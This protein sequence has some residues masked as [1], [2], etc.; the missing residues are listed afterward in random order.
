VRPLKRGNAPGK[1]FEGWPRLFSCRLWMLLFR[2]VLSQLA[3]FQTQILLE[4]TVGLLRPRPLTKWFS[5]DTL[6]HGAM[7]SCWLSDGATAKTI[8]KGCR[9]FRGQGIVQMLPHLHQSSKQFAYHAGERTRPA[10]GFLAGRVLRPR[11]SLGR[12]QPFS[13]ARRYG[14]WPVT[15]LQNLQKPGCLGFEG[16]ASAPVRRFG[17]DLVLYTLVLKDA[18][19]KLHSS[20]TAPVE[21]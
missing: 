8:V 12:W 1:P 13:R 9:V 21:R 16:P 7:P 6:A 5:H 2:S 3:A 10:E 19:M 4:R 20:A 15:A 14:K 11:V 18:F 17:P